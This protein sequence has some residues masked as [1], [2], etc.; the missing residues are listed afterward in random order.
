MVTAKIGEEE[1]TLVEVMDGD[2]RYFVNR[3]SDLI[4]TIWA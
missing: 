4:A 1:V 3:P 2:K